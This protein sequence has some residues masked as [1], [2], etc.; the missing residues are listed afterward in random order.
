MSE[1]PTQAVEIRRIRRMLRETARMA[2][3]ASLTQALAKGVRTSV[4]Q[5]NHIVQHLEKLEA[6][7]TGFFP[8]L[9][10]DAAFDDVG[11]ASAQLASYLQEDE[12]EQPRAPHGPGHGNGNVH[13]NIGGLRDLKDLKE[14]K[15]LGQIIREQLPDWMRGKMPANPFTPPHPGPPPPGAPHPHEAGPSTLTDL[16]SR[17]AE[18]GSKLQT[19]AEQLRR[20]D[21]SDEQRASLADQLSR[22]GQEQARLAREHAATRAEVEAPPEPPRPPFAARGF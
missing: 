17:L 16:E 11:V 8:P 7:P 2:K 22:L 5:Y 12:E 1:N 9:P 20:G 19:V 10:D 6:V 14:L 4:A 18:V 15:E 3:E 21:L 13:V